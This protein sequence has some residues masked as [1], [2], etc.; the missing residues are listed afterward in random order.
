MTTARCVEVTTGGARLPATVG[1]EEAR[2][3]VAVDGEALSLPTPVVCSVRPRALRVLLPRDR[4]G[5]PPATP[6]DWR[7]LLALACGPAE[8]TA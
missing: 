1:G 2:I 5:V 4:P 3:P 8:R 6:V 7:R